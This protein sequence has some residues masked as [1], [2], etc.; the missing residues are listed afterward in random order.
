MEDYYD[1]SMRALQLNGLCKNT[2]YSY[3]RSVR[4]LVEYYNKTPNII[5]EEE[6]QEYFLY[7]INKSKWAPKTMAICFSGIKFFYI[8]VLKRDWHVFSVIRVKKESRL[9]CVLSRE[10]V[11]GILGKVRTLRNY[12]YFTTVYSCGLRL[13]EALNIRTSD[14]DN[15]R[16]MIHIHLGKGSYD[17]FVPMSHNLLTLLRQYWATHKNPSLV[18]PAVGRNYKQG[19]ISKTPMAVSTVHTAFRKAKSAAGITKRRVSIH[20]L[21]HSYATHLLEEGVNLKVIKR[22]LGHSQLETTMI[23]LHLTQRGHEDAFKIIDNLMK[24]FK[25]DHNN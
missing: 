16:M 2:Q 19:A 25:Y 1:R 15:H 23:Y 17:R 4:M 21:R 11:Y 24:G 22:Y 13:R 8:N 12:T 7:R 5:S 10:E 3:T 6:L 20:T 14:I 9:P 18:F